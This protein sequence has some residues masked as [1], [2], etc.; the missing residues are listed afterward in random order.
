MKVLHNSITNQ[1]D[2]RK[3]NQKPD[4]SEN[5]NLKFICQHGQSLHPCD[6]CK[7]LYPMSLLTNVNKNYHKKK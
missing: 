6:K 5:S 4:T 3:R 2:E 7:R 1:I